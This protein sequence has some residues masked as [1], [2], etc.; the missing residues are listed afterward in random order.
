MERHM[1][2]THRNQKPSLRAILPDYTWWITGACAIAFLLAALLIDLSV[3]SVQICL[4]M[5]FFI[6]C[7]WILVAIV[8][9]K[10][11]R[12]IWTLPVERK[13]M[14]LIC[15]ATYVPIKL[16]L[17][18]IPCIAISL[19]L[20]DSWYMGIL[21]LLVV[22]LMQAFSIFRLKDEYDLTVQER[23]QQNNGP[24]S[25]AGLFLELLGD[26]ISIAV[27]SVWLPIPTSVL[28]VLFLTVCGMLTRGRGRFLHSKKRD[29][30]I[31]GWNPHWR[32]GLIRSYAGA[33]LAWIAF[34][35]ILVSSNLVEPLLYYGAFFML[36]VLSFSALYDSCSNESLR[37]LRCLP[38]SPKALITW[39]LSGELPM[40]AGIII[41]CA[42]IASTSLPTIELPQAYDR[43]IID[44]L[45]K[46]F[47]IIALALVILAIRDQSQRNKSEVI[48]RIS[49]GAI[50]SVALWISIILV[51]TFLAPINLQLSIIVLIASL[52][53]CSYAFRVAL[54]TITHSSHAYRRKS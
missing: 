47:G 41:Y 30:L 21:I 43:L 24:S 3:L 32:E 13:H 50:I 10:S 35:I 42:I 46:A 53:L 17:I 11:W 27:L 20:A 25:L 8:W 16:S 7:D 15:D 14:L 2:R 5:A 48:G 40:V 37:T 12:A 19:L 1:N 28:V 23:P 18:M 22:T 51:S 49:R 52:G 33:V 38:M 31:W 9:R 44:I 6:V 34:A 4:L 45:L 29:S 26:L 39:R 54:V 36:L